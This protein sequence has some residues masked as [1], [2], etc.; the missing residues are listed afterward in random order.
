[1]TETDARLVVAMLECV[2]ER[3]GDPTA[4]VY[5]RLFATHPELEALFLMDRGGEVRASM[6]QQALECILDHAGDRLIAPQMIAASR[7]HHDGY[8]VP[9]NRFDAFFIAL[10]DAFRDIAGADWTL[11]VDNAW[12]GMLDEFAAFR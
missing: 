2:A 3:R 1:V 6:M 10:R 4:D 12:R 5:A 7:M 9:A 8:G 11:E